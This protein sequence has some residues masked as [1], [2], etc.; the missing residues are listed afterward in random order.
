M[1]LGQ[2]LGEIAFLFFTN[3]RIFGNNCYCLIDIGYD[4]TVKFLIGAFKAA[5][6]PYLPAHPVLRLRGTK[7]SASSRG[8]FIAIKLSAIGPTNNVIPAIINCPCID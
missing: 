5:C 6:L 3:I 8:S 1:V 7:V 4:V 2:E